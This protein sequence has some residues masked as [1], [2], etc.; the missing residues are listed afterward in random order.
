L[1]PVL[2]DLTRPR[3]VGDIIGTSFSLYRHHFLL[4]ATIA[5]TVVVPLDLL[6]VG[7]IDGQLTSYD[8]ETLLGGG[9]IAYWIVYYLLL[10]PLI[11]AGHVSAVVDIGEGRTPAVGRSL[12]RAGAVLLPVMGAVVLSG[13]GVLIGFLALV[14]PGIYLAMRWYLASQTVV[15]E[16]RSPVGAL[17]RS[18]ELVTDYW[19]STFGRVLLIGLIGGL[20]AGV[21]GLP[22]GLVA[23]LAESGPLSLLGTILTDAIALSFVALASTLLYFDLRARK[24]TVPAAQPAPPTLD[25]PEA[26]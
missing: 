13:L 5:F 25:R 2:L 17:R 26:P 23:A 18:G 10:V 15:V 14:V 24:E 3:D 21:L 20:L 7:V 9:D 19:W 1:P 8:D 12:Q 6:T 11:T 22:I 4:F 16:D